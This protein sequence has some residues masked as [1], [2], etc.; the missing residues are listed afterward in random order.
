MT[1]EILKRG[2]IPICPHM[3]W[4]G[5]DGVV[6]DD[7]FLNAGLDILERLCDAIY[8]FNGWHGSNGAVE[9]H[10]HAQLWGKQVFYSI[11]AIPNGQ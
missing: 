5:M 11:K 2:H 3:L 4:E 8:M 9:E 1:V 7:I 10:D 6:S